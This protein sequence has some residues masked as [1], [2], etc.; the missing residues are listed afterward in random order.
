MG[1]VVYLEGFGEKPPGR[2][3]PE[4]TDVEIS[5]R[6]EGNDLVVQV[7]KGPVQVFRVRLKDARKPL[8]AAELT[9]FSGVAPNFT[10]RIGENRERVGGWRMGWDWMS[11]SWRS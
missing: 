10:F 7:N 4:G 2:R 3:I 9:A 6:L 1:K 5:Y 8:S 11:R